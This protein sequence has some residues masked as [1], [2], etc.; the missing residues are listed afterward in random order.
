MRDIIYVSDSVR[1]ITFSSQEKKYEFGSKI[2]CSARGNP[3]PQFEWRNKENCSKYG[4]IM[5]D[6]T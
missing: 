3:S 6:L 5:M 4:W 2:T 1:H